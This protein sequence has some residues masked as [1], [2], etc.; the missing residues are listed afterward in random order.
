MA[1]LHGAQIGTGRGSSE[2]P[3]ISASGLPASPFP[4]PIAQLKQGSLGLEGL[5]RW[6]GWLGPG[7][8]GHTHRSADLSRGQALGVGMGHESL[9]S[10]GTF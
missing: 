3:A 6:L 1:K 4:P 5:G 2:N 8:S 9:P 10:K 7:T